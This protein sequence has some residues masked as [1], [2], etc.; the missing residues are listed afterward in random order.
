MKQLLIIALATITLNA[1]THVNGNPK[2]S[3]NFVSTENKV[4]ELNDPDFENSASLMDALQNRKSTRSFANKPI[5]EQ[6]LSNLLWAAAGV[7]RSNGGRT[8]PLLGDIA[9]YV[10]MESGV[11]LYDAENHRLEQKLTDDIRSNIS[12]QGPVGK[13]PVV[14]IMTIDDASFPAFM[15]VA[16]KRA[17]GMDFY[18]GNQVA[19]STQNIYLYA[20]S[21]D[22]NAV[23][24]GG[25]HR[26]KVDEMLGLNSGHHSYLIQ[27]VGYQ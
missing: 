7:N 27:L 22:M 18:Y 15:K 9:I 17:H 5:K 6:D 4:I 14:F 12:S 10:A 23:V 20:A 26:E 24:M 13:A 1:C 8:V 3:E 16:M 25:F 19:Y 2:V 11:Y 21:N